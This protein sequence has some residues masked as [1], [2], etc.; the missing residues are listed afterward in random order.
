MTLRADYTWQ[1]EIFFTVFNIKAASQEAYGI[2]R[3]RASFAPAGDRYRFSLFG[4]NLTDE[5]Y[6]TNQILTGTTYGAEFVGALGAPRTYG[7][8]VSVKF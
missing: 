3:A 7:V 4:E 5:T 8:E 2:L 1:D 6:F